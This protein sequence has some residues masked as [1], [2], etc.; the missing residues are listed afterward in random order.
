[1][2]IIIKISSFLLL[3][4]ASVSYSFGQATNTEDTVQQENTS[5]ES[6]DPNKD[7]AL[8][9]P[10]VIDFTRNESGSEGGQAGNTDSSQ[11]YSE[12]ELL[13]NIISNNNIPEPDRV[14]GTR[15]P[16]EYASGRTGGQFSFSQNPATVIIKRKP[17]LNNGTNG[18]KNNPD[19][20]PTNPN[21]W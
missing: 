15:L 14:K 4:F 16:N 6:E 12:N 19:K 18:N 5:I 17:D 9:K 21:G 10:G 7:K 2:K 20:K 1:M 3:F 11:K 8:D 13:N